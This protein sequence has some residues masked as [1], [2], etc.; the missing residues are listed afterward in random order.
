MITAIVYRGACTNDFTGLGLV[1]KLATAI[2]VHVGPTAV[3]F[4]PA[5][6]QIRIHMKEGNDVENTTLF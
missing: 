4:P 2:T 5:R 1:H 3:H 6:L